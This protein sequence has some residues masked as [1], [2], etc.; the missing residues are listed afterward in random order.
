MNPP[1]KSDSQRPGRILVA[2]DTPESQYLIEVYMQGTSHVLTF[3]EDGDAAV[4]KFRDDVF[5]LIL[6]DVRM[7]RMDG[8]AATRAIRDIERERGTEAVPII[9]LTAGAWEEDITLSRE[10]GC[11][12]HLSKPFSLFELMDAVQA[13]LSAHPGQ[14]EVQDRPEAIPPDSLEVEIPARFEVISPDYLCA[15]RRDCETIAQL[16]ASH[17]FERIRV[18]A[19]NMK[20]TGRSYGFNRVTELGLAMETSA[21][22]ADSITLTSQ[23]ADLQGYLSHVK[24]H[25]ASAA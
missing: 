6:M 22:A 14:A 23:L 25:T 24:F 18:L 1:A 8:L 17:E 21:R 5:D 7:P 16:I 10:A 4:E 11:T 3:V 20:G 12:A 19:H 9:T 13:R 2:E 15:R